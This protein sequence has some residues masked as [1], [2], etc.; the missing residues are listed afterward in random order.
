[1]QKHILF[2]FLTLWLTFHSVV[3]FS[4][5]YSKTAWSVGP[6]WHLYAGPLDSCSIDN[7]LLLINAGFTSHFLTLQTF[8]NFFW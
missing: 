1:M 3:Q 5:A 6:L 8:L 4:T 7:V 2:T